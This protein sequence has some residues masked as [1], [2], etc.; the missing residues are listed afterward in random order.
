MCKDTTINS[1][2]QDFYLP[3]DAHMT[4]SCIL[5]VMKGLNLHRVKKNSES[6]Q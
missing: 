6:R 1:E 2:L 5:D 3:N 4:I